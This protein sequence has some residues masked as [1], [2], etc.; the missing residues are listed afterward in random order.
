M[1][2]APVLDTLCALALG[3]ARIA[4]TAA[5]ARRV[6][7]RKKSRLSMPS[8]MPFSFLIG[9]EI[10]P[11]SDC[12][13]E[14]GAASSHAADNSRRIDWRLPFKLA[15]PR[16][17]GVIDDEPMPKHFVIVGKHLGKSVADGEQ[18]G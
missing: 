8:L 16:V 11:C 15:A 12:R 2:F 14:Q 10:S 17:Q 6:V 3:A 1:G 9:A 7:L 5:L 13:A 4:T 18:A